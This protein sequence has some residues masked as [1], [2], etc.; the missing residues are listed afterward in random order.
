MIVNNA[1]FGTVRV[2]DMDSEGFHIITPD[3]DV[4]VSHEQFDL[5]GALSRHV[6]RVN[7]VTL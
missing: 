1:S 7:T 6:V 4:W 2:E 5:I 3:G